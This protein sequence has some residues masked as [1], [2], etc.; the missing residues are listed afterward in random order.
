MTTRVGFYH[1]QRSTLD[2]TLPR[3][4]Q[5]ALEGGHRVLVMAGSAERV[6]HLEAL[7]W[8][9]QPDSWLP[10]GKA[11]DADAALQPVLLTHQDDNGNSADILILTDGVVSSQMDRFDRC[12][13][14]F[15]GNDDEAVM[16][17]R[18]LWREWKTRGWSLTYYQQTERGGWEEKARADG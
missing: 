17:A 9:W 5:K 14:L 13:S 1:L 3:L 10:H 6:A 2:Q 15:D 16:K 11:G 18:D 8:T 7:L 12:L 4:V